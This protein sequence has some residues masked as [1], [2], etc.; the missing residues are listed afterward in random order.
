MAENWAW[1]LKRS[2]SSDTDIGHA[3]IEELLTAL[4]RNDWDGRDLFHIQMAIEEAVVNAIEHG[5]KRDP[6]KKVQLDFRVSPERCYLEVK[7]EGQGF[8]R[9]ELPDCT[10]DACLEL[11]RGRGVMLIEELMS[12]AKYNDIGN[13]VTMLKLR[14]DPKFDQP[15]DDAHDD[16]T[17]DDT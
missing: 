9:E 1:T 5:N 6:D 13:Q 4:Q 14:N 7:D 11:P 3:A 10:D 12:E 17:N 16:K 2:I 15:E 8:V